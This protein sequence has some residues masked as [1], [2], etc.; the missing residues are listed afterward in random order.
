MP[1]RAGSAVPK[2]LSER[3]IRLVAGLHVT[4]VEPSP[5]RAIIAAP[6][7]RCTGNV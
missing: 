4:A 3:M 7:L 6:S 1:R 2:R 5:N